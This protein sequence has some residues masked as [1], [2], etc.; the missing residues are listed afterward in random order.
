MNHKCETAVALKNSRTTSEGR[1]TSRAKRA[2][3]GLLTIL[4]LALYSAVGS[5]QQL[6]GT[7]TGTAY[8]QTGAIIPHATILLRNDAS[9]DVRKTEAGSSGNRSEEHTSEL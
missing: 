7:L 2:L 1:F 4:V 9:G 8:G 6:T 3:S 5:A